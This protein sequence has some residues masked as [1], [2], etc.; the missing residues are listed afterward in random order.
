MSHTQEIHPDMEFGPAH[1]M[2]SANYLR[3]ILASHFDADSSDRRRVLA[4]D[5][6]LALTSTGQPKARPYL[7][8]AIPMAT[9]PV[10][11]LLGLVED[12][13]HGS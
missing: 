13:A 8:S 5:T 3:D 2:G 10:C 12:P 7:R 4:A 1:G 9:G 6:W 11:S